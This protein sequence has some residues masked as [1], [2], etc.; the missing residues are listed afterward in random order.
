MKSRKGIPLKILILG[1]AGQISQYLIEKLLEETNHNLV[2]YARRAEQRL[3]HFATE[4][5]TFISGDFFEE[6]LLKESL[7][8]IDLVYLNEMRHIEMIENLIHFMEEKQVKRFIGASILGIYGEVE[9]EFGRWNDEM[10]NGIPAVHDHVTSARRI[11]ESSLDYTV[12]RLPWL[13]NEAGN[14]EYA[15]TKKGEP[16]VGVQITRQA[17][18]R[19]V[20]D[21]IKADDQTPFMHESLGLYEPGT[22]NYT[23]PSFYSF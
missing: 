3:N 16:F 2:L 4:R 17:V 15:Y 13:Y 20:L 8:G 14:E 9:G 21:I 5:V 7:E 10:L 19:A 12:L 22:E 6:E 1:A 11:E 23:K 18:A